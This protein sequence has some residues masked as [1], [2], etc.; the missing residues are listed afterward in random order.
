MPHICSAMRLDACSDPPDSPLSK[1]LSFDEIMLSDLL[2]TIPDNIAEASSRVQSCCA[3]VSQAML[4]E[5]C[6]LQ[7]SGKHGAV[8]AAAKR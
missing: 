6:C 3:E 5:G 7:H 4:T 8:R 2:A 1:Q